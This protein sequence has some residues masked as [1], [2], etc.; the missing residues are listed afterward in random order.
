MS[1]VALAQ[2]SDGST[3]LTPSTFWRPIAHGMWLGITSSPW[4][5]M[6]FALFVVGSAVGLVRAAA[7]PRGRRDPIRRFSRTDKA[8]LLTRA[9]HRCERHAWLVGRC[10]QTEKLEADHIHPHSRGG[11]TALA[12]GQVLCRRHNRDKRASVPFNWQ[13]G[14]IEKRRAVYYPPEVPRGVKRYA[15]RPQKRRMPPDA[16]TG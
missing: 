3:H 4:V 1:N 10:K 11:Q 9:G 8:I 7:H 5:A 14:Q 6:G 16:E 15:P 12:N 2:H 13:L